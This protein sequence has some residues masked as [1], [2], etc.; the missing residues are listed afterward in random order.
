MAFLTGRKEKK[1]NNI[2]YI[3]EKGPLGWREQGKGNVESSS[4]LPMDILCRKILWL[5]V[6]LTFF[7][8]VH[9]ETPASERK[10]TSFLSSL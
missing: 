3:G 1:Y 6:I 5:E 7:F 8:F 2:T 9:F 4:R 10:G